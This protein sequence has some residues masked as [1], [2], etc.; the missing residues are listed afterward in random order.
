M[1]A[2]EP[3]LEWSAA[4]EAADWILER[5]HPFAQDVGSVVPE[6]FAAYARVLHP[7][8]EW[9]GSRRRKLRWAEVAERNGRVVHPEMQFHAISQP[10]EAAS[11]VTS[12]EEPL[13]GSLPADEAGVLV[14]VLTAYTR[15]PDRCWFCLWEGW[16][17]VQGAPAEATLSPRQRWRRRPAETTGPVPSKVRAGRRVRAPGRQY[18]LYRGPVA[19]SMAFCSLPWA[20]TPALWWPDD[21]A[22]CVATEIDFS[23]TYVGGSTELVE[24][25]LADRRLEALPARLGDRIT[26]DSDRLNA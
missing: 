17:W 23:W 10:A 5:L 21:R 9:D 11:P 2:A 26:Y 7:A 15:T 20:Q 19:A 13:T 8:S 6:G 1:S 24:R 25:L 3:D 22:W 12:V 4:V 18:L 14:D 16:G